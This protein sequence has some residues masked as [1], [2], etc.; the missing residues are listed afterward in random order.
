MFC[1]VLG[2]FWDRFG[3]S[4]GR[5]GRSRDSTGFDWLRYSCRRKFIIWHNFLSVRT[6]L[7]ITGL[8]LSN[9]TLRIK[10]AYQSKHQET[11]KA[12]LNYY[13]HERPYLETKNMSRNILHDDILL[14]STIFAFT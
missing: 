9:A 8:H 13:G 12:T 4:T 1:P 11:S 10:N 14:I 5:A 2:I 6:G 7:G 3:G